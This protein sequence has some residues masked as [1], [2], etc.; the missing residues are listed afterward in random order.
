VDNEHVTP[1]QFNNEDTKVTPS[2]AGSAVNAWI[3]N[4]IAK[5][6]VGENKYIT[7]GLIIIGLLA[8]ASLY[9][10]YQANSKIDTLMANGCSPAPAG[11]GQ[12]VK[13]N[14]VIISQPI[15]KTEGVIYDYR[16]SGL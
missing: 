7:I 13:N 5:G 11:T 16:V 6:L 9:F 14:T 4:Q 2:G 1:L 8:I 12:I 10:G 15:T 3:I